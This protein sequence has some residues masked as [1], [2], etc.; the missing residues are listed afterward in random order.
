ML[1]LKTYSEGPVF[2]SHEALDFANVRHGFFTRK[3]GVST[4]L[5]D[6]LNCG[7]GSDDDT[8]TVLTNRGRVAAAMGL[9]LPQMAGLYQ[10][11]SPKCVTITHPHHFAD[12]PQADAYATAL[13]GTGLTILTA[14]CLPVLFCDAKAG[15]IGAAHAGW[16]GAT[17]GIVE[18]TVSAMKGLGAQPDEIVMVIGP[19]I[20][21]ISYQVSPQMQEE[22]AS[23]H[24]T[25]NT[26]FKPDPAA[27]EKLLFDLPRF[28]T[29]RAKA[30]GLNQIFDCGL[31]TYGKNELFF[32]HRRSIH[33]REPDSGR[34]IS[35]ITL[36]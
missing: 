31:D 32:S 10:I 25:A 16:R 20:R 33:K 1:K 29:Q 5:Y 17:A 22:I 8:Q 26:C 3:G 15:V 9:T 34:L 19:G 23:Q 28:A 12:R 21:Q 24:D 2:F 4:G 6:S 11:H 18:A 7:L 36:S 27:P 35:V 13:T 30:A 14:D